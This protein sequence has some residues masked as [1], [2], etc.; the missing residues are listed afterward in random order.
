MQPPFT[1]PEP[2]LGVRLFSASS[3]RRVL[4][5]AF[6]RVNPLR[7]VFGSA[8]KS[9]QMFV[10][11]QRSYSI[12]SRMAVI[13]MCAACYFGCLRGVGL[14]VSSGTVGWYR[15]SQ[16]TEFHDSEIASP[17]AALV[18]QTVNC[19]DR[20]AMFRMQMGFYTGIMLRLI[21]KNVYRI[22]V[23]WASSSQ[24]HKGTSKR[25]GFNPKATT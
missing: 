12:Y 5:I 1:S 7:V 17:D 16:I 24:L 11:T 13:S 14:K 2:R 21:L 23:L 4:R 25:Q 6:F 9:P 3:C 19:V 18:S 8:T 20:R 10:K 15:S 22:H